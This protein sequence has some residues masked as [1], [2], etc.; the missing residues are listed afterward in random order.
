LEGEG[1][2]GGKEGKK[3]KHTNRR[4]AAFGLSLFR[5][6]K[7]EKKRREGEGEEGKRFIFL[8][9]YLLLSLKEGEVIR[10]HRFAGLLTEAT[11]PFKWKEKKKE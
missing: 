1:G 10:F 2:R 6:I 9:W 4:N 11:L 7:K 5:K 3:S 8:V